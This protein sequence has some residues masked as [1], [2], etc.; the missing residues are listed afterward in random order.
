MKIKQC[1]WSCGGEWST[2]ENGLCGAGNVQSALG[3]TPM[4][5]T[6]ARLWGR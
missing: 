3:F 4:G 6:P 2:K 1:V 5:G